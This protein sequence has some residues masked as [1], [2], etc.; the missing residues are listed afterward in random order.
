MYISFSFTQARF[1][2]EKCD[3][4]LEI[5]NKKAKD[6]VAELQRKGYESDP[7]KEWKK[8]KDRDAALVC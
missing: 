6:M 2:L 1:I 4:R 8:L 5:E 3:G 7:V